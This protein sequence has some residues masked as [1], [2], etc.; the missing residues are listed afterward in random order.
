MTAEVRRHILIA[1]SALFLAVGPVGAQDRSASEA[2]SVEQVAREPRIETGDDAFV[3][4][5]DLLEH[6]S[7]PADTVEDHARP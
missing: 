1:V 7:V 4:L 2:E 5:S 3:E 6:T